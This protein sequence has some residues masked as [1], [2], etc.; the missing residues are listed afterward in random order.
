MGRSIGGTWGARSSALPGCP[1][2]TCA[3][4]AGA[5]AGASGDDG[6]SWPPCNMA[7]PP[8]AAAATPPCSISSAARSP[9]AGTGIEELRKCTPKE[10]SSHTCGG[11]SR[12]PPPPACRRCRSPH[13]LGASAL[14]RPCCLRLHQRPPAAA[15]GARAVGHQPENPCLPRFPALPRTASEGAKRL[16]GYCAGLELRSMCKYST[17]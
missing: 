5:A 9:A 11:M 4:A 6:A 7:G 15:W 16:C 3:G 8:A 1:G 10:G 13:C 2:T 12:M 17:R 14:T